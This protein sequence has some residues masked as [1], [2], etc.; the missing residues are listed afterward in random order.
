MP[1]A[2]RPARAS[3]TEAILRIENAVFET[4]RLSPRSIRQLIGRKTA[5][6]LVAEDEEG[7]AGYCLVLH[8]RG[9]GVARLYSIA[10]APERTGAG[11]GRRLLAAAEEAASRDGRTAL[12]L[13]VREDNAR[14]IGVYEKSGYR[15]IGRKLNYYK[16]GAAALRYEKM[17]RGGLDAAGMRG[18]RQG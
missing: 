8:R 13:E 10:V 7:V 6:V 1:V 14:A 5:E 9:S 12:R 17:L 3:D 16:D 4:D 15:R 11:V 2:I 18:K